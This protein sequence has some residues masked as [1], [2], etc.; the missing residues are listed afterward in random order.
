M[1]NDHLVHHL[2]AS[3]DPAVTLGGFSQP[4]LALLFAT[5]II[6]YI[7]AAKQTGR[8]YRRWPV[9]RV[10]YWIA[11]VLFAWLSVAGPVADRAHTD[12]TAHM[13]GHLFLGMLSPLL[14]VLAAP[15][16][17][18]LRTLPTE[19]A[20]RLTRLLKCRFSRLVTHPVTAAILNLGGLW[21]LYTSDLY[22]LM[23]TYPSLY[24]LIHF[25]VFAAGYVFTVSMLYVDP[26]PHPHSYQLRSAVLL[27]FLAGHAILSKFIYAHPPAGVPAEQA[28]AGGLVMYYGGDAIDAFLIFFLCLQWYRSVR[29]RQKGGRKLRQS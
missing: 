8:H 24:L 18:M 15:M 4:L 9:S 17:L 1:K 7:V 20:R 5:A 16:T 23:H 21:L 11:G 25:H 27:V 19:A 12:F 2:P 6:L 13:V 28:Q 10:I 22:S 26:S 3:G 29:P 14:L